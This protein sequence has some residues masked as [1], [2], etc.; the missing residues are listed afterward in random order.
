MF[1]GLL[2]K[3]AEPTKDKDNEK[4]PSDTPTLN[5]HPSSKSYAE[6]IKENARINV[7][8]S[9]SINENI[10]AREVEP[11]LQKVRHGA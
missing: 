10:L 6:G 2:K 1:L 7:P 4:I 3:P 5:D 8:R 9:N 11:F